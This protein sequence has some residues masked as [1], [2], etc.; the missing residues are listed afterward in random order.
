MAKNLLTTA[1]AILAVLV[2]GEILK[3]GLKFATFSTFGANDVNMLMSV[4][5]G[6]I[7]VKLVDQ[8]ANKVVS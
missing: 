2:F 8:V 6:M 1:V 7:I 4:A 3:Y 5:G